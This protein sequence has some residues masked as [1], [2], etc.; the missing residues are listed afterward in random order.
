MPRR[1]LPLVEPRLDSDC[2]AAISNQNIEPWTSYA[3]AGAIWY[4]GESNRWRAR[5]YAGLFPA[6]IEDWRLRWGDEF[7]FYFVQ[8]ANFLEPVSEPGVPDAW[9]EL[10]EAQRL[11]LA[12]VPKTGMAI[13]NDIGETRDIHP[14]NKRDVGHRLAR[15]ALAKNHGRPI[16]PVSGPLY[17]NHE[18]DCGKVRVF[19]DHV[20][21]GLKSRDGK[22]LARFEMAGEDRKFVWAE[23]E[24]ASDG[25]SVIVF[26]PEIPAP[27][28]VRYAWASNPEG[29]NLANSADLPASLFRTDDWELLTDGIETRAQ[30]V[31]RRGIPESSK[32]ERAIPK[33]IP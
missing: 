24:I 11:T 12:R 26:S 13:I 5:Q 21:K 3:I 30:E 4:Q 20:G 15:W 33:A 17:R 22:K 32:T 28:A 14:K 10:Q 1:P 7:P 16:D 27:A 23:A 18:I 9:A 19:F 8:L 31:E 29:A 6:L 2:P 25:G